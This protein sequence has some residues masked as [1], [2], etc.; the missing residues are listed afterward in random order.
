MSPSWSRRPGSWA[1]QA[2]NSVALFRRSSVGVIPDRT[3]RLSVDVR[4]RHSVTMRKTSLMSLSLRRVW[5]LRLQTGAQYSAAEW[6]KAKVA[7]RNDLVPAP[8]LD[9]ARRLKRRT[10]VV[11]FLQSHSRCRRYVS[12]L[13]NLMMDKLAQQRRAGCD[14]RQ[15]PSSRVAF[16][17]YRWKAAV[18]Y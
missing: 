14:L 10:C 15:L 4:R 3:N 8:Q 2:K 6:I 12:D 18:W 7:I 17:L 11:N 16:L 13:S 9:P 5:A 1:R